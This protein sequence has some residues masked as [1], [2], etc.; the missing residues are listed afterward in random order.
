MA[1]IDLGRISFKVCV[2]WMVF[3]EDW[4]IT[5][6]DLSFFIDFDFK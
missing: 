1:V 2:Q 5:L 4:K 3:S 6:I